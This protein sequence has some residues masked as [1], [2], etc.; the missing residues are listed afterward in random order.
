MEKYF[1][2][3]RNNIIGI[4]ETIDTPFLKNT[5]IVYADWTASGRNYKIIEERIQ[6][7]L[8]PFV[9]NT[10]TETNSTG[11]AMTQAYHKSRNI[12]KQHVNANEQDVLISNYSGMTGVANKF[13]RILGFKIYEKYKK[14][15]IIAEE[16]RPI[17][18]ITHMEHHSNQTSWLETI[19]DVEI[20]APCPQGLVNTNNLKELLEKYKNRKT[21]VASITACSNVTGIATP[22]HK[23][24]KIMHEANGVCFVD[25]ACSAP[26]VDINMH[27]NDEEYLDAIFFSPHKFLGGPG[28]SG[29]L[30]FNSNLYKNTVPDNPGGGT[31][32]WTNPWGGHKYI[33]DIEEREDGGTPAFLQTI[34]TA[35]CIQLKEEMGVENILKR[36]EEQLKIVW[37]GLTNI[38]NLHILADQHKNRLGVISFYIDELHFNVGVKMLNDKFGVQTRGGCSCAG[39]YGHYLLHVL[40]EQSGKITTAIDDG[41]LSNKPGWIRMSIHPTMTNKEIEY[42]IE[43]IKSLAQNF[44]EW[45]GDYNLKKCHSEVLLNNSFD[46]SFIEK[47]ISNIFNKK[48]N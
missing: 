10:H 17:V 29:I 19:A 32:E 26:Y 18:F 39:T 44:K 22:Y 14:Q 16:D 40:P 9:A 7:E 6:N 13:Q 33:Q 15:V 36:E 11:Q 42:V 2:K 37:N 41:D 34:K 12:I 1:E 46:D 3:Y 8:M 31:V 28:S 24:A 4:N 47:K 23:I 48:Y 21:K 5:S 43:S 45:E 38:S 20:I 27:P 35:M 30:I 25:F